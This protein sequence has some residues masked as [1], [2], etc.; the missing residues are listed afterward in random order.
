MQSSTAS[1]LDMISDTSL[2]LVHDGITE[3]NATTSTTVGGSLEIDNLSCSSATQSPIRHIGMQSRIAFDL[4]MI[5]DRP[6]PMARADDRVALFNSIIENLQQLTDY[7]ALES[8]AKVAT[9][10]INKSGFGFDS[11]YEATADG[12]SIDNTTSATL[13]NHI[14]GKM[15]PVSVAGDGNYLPRAGSVLAFGHEDSHIEIRTRIIIEMIQNKQLY[16]NPTYLNKGH[17]V[18]TTTQLCNT[19]CTQTNTSLP[20]Q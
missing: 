5:S 11:M 18:Q 7:S 17:R 19:Q 9:D 12:K 14:Q 6:L 8:A 20:K 16:F 13:Q 2:P 15:V 10:M 3:P 1:D 4:D